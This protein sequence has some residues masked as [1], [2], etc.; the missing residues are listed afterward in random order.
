LEKFFKADE[1]P[2]GVAKTTQG[3]LIEPCESKVF[4]IRTGRLKRPQRYGGKV[5]FVLTVTFL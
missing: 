3:E 5:E 1:P 2:L 4:A